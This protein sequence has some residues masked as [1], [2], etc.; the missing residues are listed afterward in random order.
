MNSLLLPAGKHN[1]ELT[2]ASN[3]RAYD[4]TADK[5]ARCKS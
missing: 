5:K 1:D 2:T 3:F 4:I